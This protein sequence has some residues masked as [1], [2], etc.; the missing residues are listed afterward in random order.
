LLVLVVSGVFPAGP[1]E[2]EWAIAAA[3]GAEDEAAAAG[4]GELAAA[5]VFAFVPGAVEGAAGFGEFATTF[6]VVGGPVAVFAAGEGD[7]AKGGLPG[8]V[9]EVCER[10]RC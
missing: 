9:V 8:G 4:G 7:V 3:V 5:G 10:G 1:G 6:A 2:Q